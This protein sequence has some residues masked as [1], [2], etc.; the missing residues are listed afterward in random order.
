M[1]V[2]KW[3]F[4]VLGLAL[5]SVATVLTFLK[6]VDIASMFKMLRQGAPDEISPYIWMG[7]GAAALGGLLL[8]LGIG[9]AGKTRGAV[10]EE[11]VNEYKRNL[12][13]EATK[14]RAEKDPEPA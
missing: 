5:L 3:I 2:M 13:N 7:L 8:G 14:G 4:A 12:L 9:L 11:A 6:T 1:K 10:R